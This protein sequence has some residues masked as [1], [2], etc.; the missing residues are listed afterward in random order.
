MP[1]PDPEIT[2][3][4]A[5]IRRVAASLVRGGD[6][7]DLAQDIWL[8]AM[9]NP[10]RDEAAVKPWLYGIARNLHRLRRR[11]DRRRL[12]RETR[13]ATTADD[14]APG[15]DALLERAAAERLVEHALRALEEPFRT[16]VWL[17]YHED[18][19]AAEIARRQ[20]VPAGTVRWR[21][22]VALDRMREDLDRRDERGHRGVALLA[23][24]LPQPTPPRA[25]PASTTLAGLGVCAAIV[26][27][28]AVA[29]P[30]RGGPARRSAGRAVAAAVVP[31]TATPPRA[32]AVIPSARP[33]PFGE[34]TVTRDPRAPHGS[35]EGRVIDWTT[36]LGVPGAEVVFARGEEA[37]TLVADD[38]GR[39]RYEP[40]ADGRYLVA[41]ATAA[42]YLPFAPAWGDS[43]VSFVSRPELA[44]HDVSIHLVPAVDM[45]G[46]VVGPDGEP[47]AG[48][49]VRMRDAPNKD[50]EPL[51]DRFVTDARGEF[52]FRG[53]E[54]AFFEAEREGYGAG[55]AVLTVR[56]ATLRRIEIALARAGAPEPARTRIR[57]RLVDGD[58]APVA[59]ALVNLPAGEREDHPGA[60]AL[61]DAEGRFT[62][63]DVRAGTYALHVRHDGRVPWVFD[64]VRAGDPEVELAIH[65]GGSI[66]GR[67]VRAATGEAVPLFTVTLGRRQ[68]ARFTLIEGRT[69]L[70][71]EGRFSLEGVEPGA[72]QLSVSARGLV[73]SP[74][75]AVEVPGLGAPAAPVEVA[76][77]RGGAITGRIVDEDGSPI[78]D[79]QVLLRWGSGTAVD[80]LSC[81]PV[82]FTDARGAFAITGVAPGV[83]S[84]GVLAEDHH[85]RIVSGVPV[86]EGGPGAAIT[87]RLARM[88]PGRP[89]L[90]Q[91]G[92]L[93]AVFHAVED[94]MEVVRVL[95]G[96]GAE[97]AGLGPGDAVLAL[98]G[99]P[100]TEL[101]RAR[102]LELTRSPEEGTPARLRVRRKETGA[103]TDMLVERRLVLY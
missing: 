81:D 42:G 66:A 11:T 10:P 17:R 87:V 19:S 2:S 52:V 76:L 94:A 72:Y 88:T 58:G 20:G 80:G 21:L 54:F 69:V 77:A 55:A 100:V 38:Q 29:I 43:A 73:T 97:R 12:A 92:G 36:G 51:T 9:Q 90:S 79:A 46:V 7:D 67:V 70:D 25:A 23:L 74:E 45:T 3:H 13:I 41:M 59:R 8:A 31:P 102:F 101:A 47:V 48:A 62:I 6:A 32:A 82:A 56:R 27:L 30:W 53:P 57:G 33:D 91:I 39:F 40:A 60:L 44:F 14:T 93:G 98:D 65:R 18:L 75:I 68:G 83:A 15:A 99:T 37:R 5:W 49:R 22:K 95:P 4:A 84:L 86:P 85:V 24:G 71:G 34:V 28:I 1:S 64:G 89:R 35:M 78:E 96:S 103:I 16:T 26:A 63:E 61:T 50:L